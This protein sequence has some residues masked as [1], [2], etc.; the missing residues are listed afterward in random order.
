MTIGKLITN[1]P[2][3]V[4]LA[5]RGTADNVADH[6]TGYD[7]QITS[8]GSFSLQRSVSANATNGGNVMVFSGNT[9][10]FG[11]IAPGDVLTVSAVGSA[12]SYYRNNI[13]EASYN[14]PSPI[15]GTTCG[16]GIRDGSPPVVTLDHYFTNI[17]IT[18]ILANTIYQFPVL[19]H[20]VAF[21]ATEVTGRAFT[22]PDGTT[23]TTVINRG[24]MSAYDAEV[25]KNDAKRTIK[26]L[27]KEYLLQARAELDKLTGTK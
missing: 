14:D 18:P 27:K 16:F 3:F 15:S 26:I 19:S 12:I 4:Q 6:F 2:G 5:V 9:S 24:I 25:L 17:T 23:A 13:L 8:N 7:Y 11:Q 21:Q 10:P 1:N 20:N 22:F